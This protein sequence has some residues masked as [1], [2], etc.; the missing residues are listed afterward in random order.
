[1]KARSVALSLFIAGLIASILFFSSGSF[2]SASHE[3]EVKEAIV[4]DADIFNAGAGGNSDVD[5]DTVTGL[6][7]CSGNFYDSDNTGAASTGDGWDPGVMH[8]G[9]IDSCAVRTWTTAGTDNFAFVDFIIKD[10]T[11]LTAWQILLKFDNTKLGFA[12]VIDLNGDGTGFFPFRDTK[13][14][15]PLTLSQFINFLNLPVVDPAAPPGEGHNTTFLVGPSTSSSGTSDW[16]IMSSAYLP[17]FVP[18]DSAES[19]DTPSTNAPKGG[20]LVRTLW[21]LL[22]AS[23]GTVV[24]IDIS[25]RQAGP[26]FPGVTKTNVLVSG[27]DTEHVLPESHLGDVHVASDGPAPSTPA[28]APPGTPTPPAPTSEPT[29]AP[30]PAPTTTPRTPLPPTSAPEE[31]TGTVEEGGTVTTDTEGDGDDGSGDGSTEDDPI[32]TSVTSPNAGTISITETS[33]TQEPPTGF[34][35]FG[36]QVNISAPGATADDPL[37]IK[38]TIDSS[39]I[40][41]G[42][43]EDTIQIFKDGVQVPACTGAAGTASPDPCVSA[44][45][46]LADGDVAV[47]V[48]A[49]T[50]GTW[51]FG[52]PTPTP[53]ATAAP[54]VAALVDLVPPDGGGPPGIASSWPLYSLAASLAVL[55]LTG[56]GLAWRARR[57]G[58]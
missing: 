3:P 21:E 10:V 13:E 49:S 57:R 5:C 39:I 8:I 19:P 20:L 24:S 32:E 16:V 48:L 56:G 37:V 27:L 58:A 7:G 17:K 54:A 31:E 44:R 42:A 55:A 12:G 25:A 26:S 38:F 11:D 14:G 6:F 47:T 1:M 4:G 18:K 41:E 30:T 34:T 29:P 51:N 9:P 23:D 22:P 15:G 2:S 53:A 33:I 46:T 52:L 28:C 43:D 35:F 45:D 50:P 36:Q 40:P